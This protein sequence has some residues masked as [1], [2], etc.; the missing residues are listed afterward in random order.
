MTP[1]ELVTAGYGAKSRRYEK[2]TGEDA[3]R[4]IARREYVDMQAR[5]LGWRDWADYQYASKQAGGL[6]GMRSEAATAVNWP[7]QLATKRQ[8]EEDVPDLETR[9]ERRAFLREHAKELKAIAA[10]PE[11]MSAHGPLATWLEELGIREQ[12]APY[13]VGDTP[14]VRKR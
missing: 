1:A 7:L 8:G 5:S 2:L 6:G 4:T 11:D 14:R 12:G 10:N 13:A 9:E 3:G